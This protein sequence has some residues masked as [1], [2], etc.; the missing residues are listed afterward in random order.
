MKKVLLSLFLAIAALGVQAQDRQTVP[1]VSLTIKDIAGRSQSPFKLDGQQATVL[2]FILQDC[3][4]SNRFAPEI[5]RIA[6]D[7]KSKP[8]RFFLVYVDAAASVKEIEK[9]GREFN[10]PGVPVIHDV[11]HQLVAAAG[12]SITPEVAVVGQKGAIVYRGRIDNLYEALGKPRRVVT[13]RDL[14]NAL[15]AVLQNRKVPI[16]R[17]ST[18]GCYITA[19]N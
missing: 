1:D 6:Q 10:L 4:I 18:I 3:P 2:F 8:V 16:A 7:Y 13:E 12:A 14:R 11:K 15:E 17:T 5:A 9:H 19:Q